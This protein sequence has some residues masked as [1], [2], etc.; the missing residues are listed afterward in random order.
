LDA[1]S[2]RRHHEGQPGRFVC[3]VVT[4]NGCGMEPGLVRRIFEPFFTTKEVGKGTGLGLATVYAV[5]KQHHGWIEVQSEI[6]SGSTFKIYL[7]ASD[8]VLGASPTPTAAQTENIR[9]GKETILL[10]ED[11]GALL[12]LMRHVLGQY[13]YNI[14]TASSG[15]E[16]L[17]VWERNRGHIDLLLTDLVMPGGMTGRELATE[18]KKRNPELKVIL[19]SGF[20]ASTMGKERSTG[21]TVF[22]AKPYLPDTAA[23]LIR[24]TLDTTPPATKAA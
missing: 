15:R 14:L 8:Q 4:D 22:L 19:T 21:D 18:L 7:P 10:A 20:N 2:A 13:Q 6:G 12:E 11:E 24:D 23:K 5:V 1:T 16:A 9:G 17:K 3:L